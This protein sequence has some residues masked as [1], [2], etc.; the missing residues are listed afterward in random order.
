MREASETCTCVVLRLYLMAILD[1]KMS[2]Y[3]LFVCMCTCV[4]PE[5]RKGQPSLQQ[6]E[7]WEVVS[8][9]V[10]AGN[11]IAL[12][13]FGKAVSVYN[14][15]S[16]KGLYFKSSKRCGGQELRKRMSRKSSQT[17]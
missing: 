17:E 8:P 10:S 2:F 12:W 6:L 16:S 15:F 3:F 1:F 13:S 11:Q 7:I 14:L 9:H 5:A 4:L